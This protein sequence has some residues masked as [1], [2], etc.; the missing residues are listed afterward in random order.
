[1]CSIIGVACSAA[2]PVAKFTCHF[3]AV[4]A[5][6][7]LGS[8]V[9]HLLSRLALAM[10][11]SADNARVEFYLSWRASYF[12]HVLRLRHPGGG[13]RG[14]RRRIVCVYV[15]ALAHA[16]ARA[17][18]SHRTH[19]HLHTHTHTCMFEIYIFNRTHASDPCRCIR[20]RQ[21]ATMRTAGRVL[22]TAAGAEG[23]LLR[24][25]PVP[26]PVQTFPA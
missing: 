3:L 4:S 11:R 18:V 26:S 7:V 24:Y 23:A 8:I 16:F 6:T 2:Q 19:V 12:L 25:G 13:A 14:A 1:M 22:R 17:Y 9:L 10:I 15:A 21:P 5:S 20:A